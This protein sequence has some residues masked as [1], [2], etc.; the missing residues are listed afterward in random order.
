MK[1]KQINEKGI[2]I[3]EVLIVL[4]VLSF[5]LGIAYALTNRA[6]IAVRSAQE[7]SEAVKIASTQLELAKQASAKGDPLLNNPKTVPYCLNPPPTLTD[8]IKK[9]D[10]TSPGTEIGDRNTDTLTRYPTE[11]KN[12]I[13]HKSVTFGED[14]PANNTDDITVRVRWAALGGKGNAEVVLKYKL[15][16]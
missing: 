14:P 13:F 5:S 3:V 12:G 8:N 1:I 16:K 10:L 6:F 15:L 11:C 9:K 7:R 4:A 2:T